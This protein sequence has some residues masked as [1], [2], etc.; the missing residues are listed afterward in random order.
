[1]S[2]KALCPCIASPSPLSFSATWK[3][4]S[5]VPMPTGHSRKVTISGKLSMDSGVMYFFAGAPPR[6]SACEEKDAWSIQTMHAGEGVQQYA[7]LH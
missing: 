6:A 2:G 5:L 3:I 7:C 4:L 1:M